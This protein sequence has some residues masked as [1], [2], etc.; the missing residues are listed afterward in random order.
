MH[1]VQISIT[2][3]RGLICVAGVGRAEAVLNRLGDRVS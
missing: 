2:P 3:R 1:P